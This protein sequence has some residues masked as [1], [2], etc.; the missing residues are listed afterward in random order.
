MLSVVEADITMGQGQIGVSPC[1]ALECQ[2]FLWLW[3]YY[4]SLGIGLSGE[5][6]NT[7]CHLIAAKTEGDLSTQLRCGRRSVSNVLSQ[8]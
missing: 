8:Y 7:P 4:I 5:G 6:D 2:T 3:S 1:M